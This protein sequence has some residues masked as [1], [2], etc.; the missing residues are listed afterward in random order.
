MVIY[1]HVILAFLEGFASMMDPE[2]SERVSKRFNLL[3]FY[4][5]FILPVVFAFSIMPLV[6]TA[7]PSHSRQ[8]G[9]AHLIGF[10]FSTL[11]YDLIFCS[12]LSYLTKEL[13]AYI[14]SIDEYLLKDLKLVVHRLNT[15]YRVVGGNAL[16]VGIQGIAFSSSNFL[17]HLNTYQILFAFSLVPA[18]LYF[19][20]NRVSRS[21]DNQIIPINSD[22]KSTPATGGSRDGSNLNY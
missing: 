2:S 8:L 5:W 18:F 1:L 12:S 15:A 14:N 13:N 6:S 7:Y 20:V 4:S 21:P 10:G 22:E 16:T 3:G 11:V 19:F 17:F 9:G